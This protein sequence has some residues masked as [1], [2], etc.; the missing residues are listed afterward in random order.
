MQLTETAPK[1]GSGGH[2]HNV[3]QR[4]LQAGNWKIEALQGLGAV[5]RQ[6]PLSV[7]YFVLCGTTHPA[8]VGGRCI[9]VFRAVLQ[10]S[11]LPAAMGICADGLL[12]LC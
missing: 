5:G 3:G 1:I 9:R 12:N 8:Y 11:T 7:I 6:Q 2:S 4:R 10:H